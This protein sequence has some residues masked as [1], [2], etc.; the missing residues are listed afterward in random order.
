MTIAEAVEVLKTDGCYE[1]TWGCLSPYTCSN[2]E[3][4]VH[5]AVHVLDKM[6]KEINERK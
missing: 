2:D 3:C 1:C 6:I 4:P 5:K